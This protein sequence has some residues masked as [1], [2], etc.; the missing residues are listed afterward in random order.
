MVGWLPCCGTDLGD[1]EHHDSRSVW[2]RRLLTSWWPGS[3]DRKS[4][5]PEVS[6]GYMSPSF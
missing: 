6:F 1:T 2:H 5:G 3:R 4:K